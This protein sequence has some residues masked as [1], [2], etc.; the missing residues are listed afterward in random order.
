MKAS[1]KMDDN[2][3]RREKE[4][5][6]G[7]KERKKIGVSWNISSLWTLFFLLFLLYFFFFFFYCLNQCCSDSFGR[8]RIAKPLQISSLKRPDTHAKQFLP[9][10][11]EKKE[12]SFSVNM[13]KSFRLHH[14]TGHSLH[15]W[16]YVHTHRGE[17]ERERHGSG[18]IQ[19]SS[20]S[21]CSESGHCLLWCV[22][23][24]TQVSPSHSPQQ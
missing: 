6:K 14:R 5:G 7:K 10:K 15:S 8:Q 22:R 1:K 9:K 24:S 23:T 17:I 21:H 16:A 12:R 18:T 4:K 19:S 2:F 11:G 20:S 13:K 3:K